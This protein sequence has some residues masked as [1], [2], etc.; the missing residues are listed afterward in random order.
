MVNR[1]SLPS[2]KKKYLAVKSSNPLNLLSA[3]RAAAARRRR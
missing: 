2:G 3:W 1:K